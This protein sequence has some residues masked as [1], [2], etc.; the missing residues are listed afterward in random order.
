MNT[1]TY[2]LS[3]NTLSAG[4]AGVNLYESG[5]TNLI[6][7]MSGIGSHADFGDYRYLKFLVKYSDLDDIFILQNTTNLV[8]GAH[9]NIDRRFYPT[10]NFHTTYTIDVSGI[11]T[12]LIT[13]LYRINF[14]VSKPPLNH[15]K[16][17]KIVNTYLHSNQHGADTLLVTV[18]ADNPNYVS[19]LLIPFNKDRSVYLPNIPE[20]FI[21]NDNM[22]LR[23]EIYTVGGG[24]KPVL[25]ELYSFGDKD[26]DFI[27]KEEQ[28][29]IFAIGTN[30][31]S[32]GP[33]YAGHY[34]LENLGI[35][36]VTNINGVAEDPYLILVPED[37]ID[38]SQDILDDQIPNVSIDGIYPDGFIT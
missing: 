10:D 36:K 18:E 22:V 32:Q 29:Q 34:Q 2:V 27:I 12:D 37:G 7:S 5:P 4:D 38:Y 14:T 8:S 16:D 19:N 23:S 9:L 20:P 33:F 25:T 6:I 28:Y 13:D 31:N 11:R 26:S 21:A 17:Y 15:Y 35:P 3:S 30:E 1:L 24:F